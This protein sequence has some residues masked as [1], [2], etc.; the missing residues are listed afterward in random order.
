M[1]LFASLL[2]SSALTATSVTAQPLPDPVQT[3]FVPLPEQDLFDLF[4]DIA[5]GLPNGTVSGNVNT[6]ISI[7]IAADNTIIYY[8]NWEDGFEAHAKER[9]QTTTQIWGDGDLTNGIAP[10][11]TNDRL[12]GGITIFLENPAVVTPARGS[13]PIVYH[14]RGRIQAS[15]PWLVLRELGYTFHR[16]SWTEQ[17]RQ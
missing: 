2:L 9:T 5:V 6:V 14:G 13:T 8:D 11:T 7:A 12:L 1:N 16:S 3:Y 17:Y 4:T 10:G 15:L